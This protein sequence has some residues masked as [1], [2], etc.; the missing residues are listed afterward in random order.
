MIDMGEGGGGGAIEKVLPVDDR[1]AATTMKLRLFARHYRLKNVNGPGLLAR[2]THVHHIQEGVQEA[3]SMSVFSTSFPCAA[4][5]SKRWFLIAMLLIGLSYTFHCSM[6]L[7]IVLGHG[8]DTGQYLRFSALQLRSESAAPVPNLTAPVIAAVGPMFNG[9]QGFDSAWIAKSVSNAHDGQRGL[10]E[11]SSD[12]REYTVDLGHQQQV[13]GYFFQLT[14]EPEAA[15]DP[16]RFSAELSADRVTWKPLAGGSKCLGQTW[17]SAT[18]QTTTAARSTY[19]QLDLR[20][21]LLG[22]AEAAGYL[23]VCFGCALILLFGYLRLYDLGKP[24]MITSLSFLLVCLTAS[25]LSDVASHAEGVPAGSVLRALW[26]RVANIPLT[27]SIVCVLVFKEAWII[28]ALFASGSLGVTLYFTSRVVERDEA[29][30]CLHGFDIAP[31]EKIAFL[32]MSVIALM[33]RRRDRQ[34]SKRM[35]HGDLAQYQT[36]WDHLMQ[37]RDERRAMHGIKQILRGRNCSTTTPPSQLYQPGL[38]LTPAATLTFKYGTGSPSPGPPLSP[39]GR[40]AGRGQAN[41]TRFESVAAKFRAGGVAQLIGGS[42]FLGTFEGVSRHGR[43]EAA[44]LKGYKAVPSLDILYTHAVLVE[45]MMRSKVQQ[46]GRATRALVSLWT[47]AEEAEGEGRGGRSRAR[48]IEYYRW[49]DVTPELLARVAWAPIKNPK[50]TI[51]KLVRSYGGKACKLLDVCRDSLVFEHTWELEEGLKSIL[52]DKD[53]QVVYAKDRLGEDYDAEN[54]SSG[55]RDV[56]LNL[57]IITDETKRL[58]IAGH[59]VEIQLQLLQYAQI[60]KLGGGHKR[61]VAVRNAN[62]Q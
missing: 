24:T 56:L 1:E 14:P 8:Q 34:V 26:L 2:R 3:Q 13:N 61:Y 18:H 46:W 49:A 15:L 43:R 33:L 62:G 60:K 28:N 35:V 12:F 58:G 20:I 41:N 51:E 30:D 22:Y 50:R 16:V 6:I 39:T 5:M 37:D 57:R 45:P 55:Y 36:I 59:V 42:T 4:A 44:D 31:M 32:I 47:P 11:I 23:V 48:S 40:F 53:I 25:L 9:C 52:E 19:V 54:K 38:A 10:V 17:A 21:P 29:D 27:A 7:R